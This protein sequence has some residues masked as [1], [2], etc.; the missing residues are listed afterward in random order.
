MMEDFFEKHNLQKKL[1]KR[2]LLK[3]KFDIFP[4]IINSLH[5]QTKNIFL[6][7]CFGDLFY[8]QEILK[9]NFSEEF[10]KN[11]LPKINRVQLLKNEWIFKVK[12]FKF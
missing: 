4:L 8:N 9:T 5:S 12:L 1:R 2:I 10:L 6:E 7:K 11:L 3:R